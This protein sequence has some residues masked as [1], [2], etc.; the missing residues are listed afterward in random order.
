M[1]KTDTKEFFWK[2]KSG[3]EFTNTFSTKELKKAFDDDTNDD[4]QTIK[5]W[6]EEDPD[7]G[8]TWVNAA[9]EVTRIK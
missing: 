1:D 6:L 7:I 9:N 4:G 8:S 3:R 2:D 5:E